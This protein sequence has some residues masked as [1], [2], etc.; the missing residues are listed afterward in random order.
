MFNHLNIY[1]KHILYYCTK[2]MTTITELFDSIL[3]FI[4]GAEIVFKLFSK[5]LLL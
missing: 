5:H 1:F 4:W 2:Q 3:F